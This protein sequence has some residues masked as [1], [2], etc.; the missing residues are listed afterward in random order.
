[1]SQPSID[2]NVRWRLA[3]NRSHDLQRTTVWI[4]VLHG[5]VVCRNLLKPF[6]PGNHNIVLE[7]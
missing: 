1:M 5:E 7:S 6:V 2:C 3:R 4:G